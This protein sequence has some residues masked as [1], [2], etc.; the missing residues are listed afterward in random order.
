[1]LSPTI[2]V[3]FA[4]R[5]S[6]TALKLKAWRMRATR[7][8]SP[9]RRRVI[10]R[11]GGQDGKSGGS[12]FARHDFTRR[13][14]LRG[15]RSFSTY[16]SRSLQTASD[17]QAP[18]G[19]A[20]LLNQTLP[21]AKYWRHGAAIVSASPQPH[22]LLTCAGLLRLQVTISASIGRKN[23]CGSRYV[24]QTQQRDQRR[25]FL[26]PQPDDRCCRR[27]R[28]DQP[29]RSGTRQTVETRLRS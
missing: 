7:S 27:R 26:A 9:S 24:D 10:P 4:T 28:D 3:R 21:R 22:I 12:F 16:R 25:G 19:H 18:R 20:S 17:S 14:P 5:M 8:P 23:D 11:A 13:S 29:M 6:P 15:G 1:L 2:A